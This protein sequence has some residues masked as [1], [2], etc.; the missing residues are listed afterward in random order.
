MGQIQ[1]A[2]S[3]VGGLAVDTDSKAARSLLYG[4]SA[5]PLTRLDGAAANALDHHMTAGGVNDGVYRPFRTDRFGG[6]ALAMNNLL[7]SEPFEGT[8]VSTSRLVIATTTF[9]N[10]QTAVGGLNLNSGNSLASAA[11]VLIQSLRQF[12]KCQRAP[13]QSKWRL[14]AGQVA[15]CVMEWGFGN[16]ANQ[17]STPTIGAYFQVTAGGLVQAILNFGGTPVQ[18]GTDITMPGGWQSNFYTWD[19]LLDDDAATF[20]VQ[21]TATE[22]I[23]A[24]RTFQMPATQMRLWNATHLPVFARAHNTAATASAPVFILSSIDVISLDQATNK[25]W[26][27][28]MALN[29]QGAQI[30]PVAFTQTAQWANS[31]APA[32]ATLSNTAAGY[33]TL[34]GLFSFAAVAGAATD[35]ALFG[36]TVPA[37]YSLV[38]T[39][40]DI[41]AWN[42]GAAVATTPHLLAWGAGVD[43]S[44]ISL[45][46]TINRVP[47][48]VQSFPIGAVPGAKAE[49]ITADFTHSPL[50]TNP[51]RIFTLM[52]RMPVATATASQVVQG[53]ANVKGYF[54]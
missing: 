33:A 19:V 45:A 40:I 34:G 17:T 11:A 30:G 41:E 25:P 16:P 13:L 52:L 49:R 53:M 43:Q 28:Q 15:N 8:N 37:P 51:G 27:H 38:V 7:M 48:G 6:Q 1:D 54:E 47:L 23:I 20:V 3:I 22:A 5:R 32:N 36:F 50:V 29:G 39:G 26:S 4:P 46:G 42:T 31:A 12:P 9:T 18:A 21:D 14:R 10:A 44:A 2:S 35:Y 24:T